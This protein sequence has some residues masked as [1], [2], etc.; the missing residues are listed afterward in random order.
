MAEAKN[1]TVEK[2]VTETKQATAYTLTLSQD[3]AEALQAL[4]G[5]V[6]GSSSTSPRK[7]TDAVYS[8]LER[9][10]VRTYLNPIARQFTGSVRWL[11][12]PKSIA[13]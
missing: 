9:A 13:W 2:L 11:D 10:G 3:E 1:T 4:T 7:H 6:T 8:A 12:R 5:Y